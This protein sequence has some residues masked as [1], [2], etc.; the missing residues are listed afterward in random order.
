M[1]YI[2]QPRRVQDSGMNEPKKLSSLQ[3]LIFDAPLYAVY[4]MPQGHFHLKDNLEGYC[5]GCRQQSIFKRTGKSVLE[6]IPRPNGGTSCGEI[7]YRCARDNE[8][9]IRIQ[10][11]VKKETIEKY[12]QYPPFADVAHGE[13]RS[14]RKGLSEQ[15]G[16]EF[17]RAIGLESHGVGIG[18]FVYMRRIFE[19]VIKNIFDEVKEKEGWTEADYPGRIDE[20]ITLLKDHLPSFL[21]KNARLYSILSLGIHELDEQA[22]LDFFDVARNSITF[23]LD[24]AQ[25]RKEEEEERRAA[26]HAISSYKPATRVSG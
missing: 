1:A 12:G 24:E 13:L 26:E 3:E 8:H 10:V 20:R 19:R 2:S 4:E 16:R 25:R 18:S 14:R 11:R 9:M 17:Y 6:G 22:C 15:D 21:V 23:I 5:V 7:A